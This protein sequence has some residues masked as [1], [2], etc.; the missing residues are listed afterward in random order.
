VTP[1]AGGWGELASDPERT[2]NADTQFAIV[3]TN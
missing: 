2:Q 3:I 1:E